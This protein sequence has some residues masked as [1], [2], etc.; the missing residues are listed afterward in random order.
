MSTQLLG[1]LQI[2][3]TICSNVNRQEN[4]GQ[5][6]LG[7]SHIPLFIYLLKYGKKNQLHKLINFPEFHSLVLL[8]VEFV[9]CQEIH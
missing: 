8:L 5:G 2:L 4:V 9:L 1:Q 6:R 3:P 7:E